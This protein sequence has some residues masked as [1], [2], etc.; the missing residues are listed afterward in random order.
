VVRWLDSVTSTQDEAHALAA[1]GAPH[2]S[3]VAAR[4]QTEGRGTRGRRWESGI[5]GLWLSVVCRP[6]GEVA[7][8]ATGLRVGLALAEM[9]DRFLP[10]LARISLKWPN[11]L[12]LRGSKLGGILM[13]ARWQG[14]TLGW[15]VAGVGINV[16]NEIPD[17]VSHPVTRLDDVGAGF[18]LEQMAESVAIAVAEATRDAGPLSDHE[19]KAFADRDWML[20]RE[21]SMPV[22]GVALGI[23]PDGQLRVK[24]RDG[25]LVGVTGN[26]T[27]TGE[28]A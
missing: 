28:E 26:V 9:I 17:S 2:G 8:A 23:T 7:L 13:E 3:A 14:E 22:V 6:R 27:L 10:P 12:L 19:I 25:S 18:S 20:G 21:I 16:R 15:M 24:C 5:G 11:D 1:R 4:I